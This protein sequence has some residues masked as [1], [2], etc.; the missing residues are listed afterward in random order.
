MFVGVVLL[1]CWLL[2]L[3]ACPTGSI[4]HATGDYSTAIL[5]LAAIAGLVSILAAN[6]QEPVLQRKL[7]HPSSAAGA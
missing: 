5:V 7:S 6:F 1:S 4:K 2:T 3:T